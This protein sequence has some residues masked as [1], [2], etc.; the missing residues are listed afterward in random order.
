M[1]DQHNKPRFE[2]PPWEKEAFDRFQQ[3]RARQRA[4][5]ELDEAIRLVRLRKDEPACPDAVGLPPSEGAQSQPNKGT[6]AI[7]GAQID[8]MLVELRSEE[9]QTVRTNMPLINGVSVALGLAGV[10]IVIQSAVL[11]VNART[12]EAV[13]M[14]VAA[15]M[16]FVVLATGLG[17]MTAAVLLFRKYHR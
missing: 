6:P 9:Q 5:E 16:S 17:F 7:L 10:L 14:M 1:S 2:P 12:S 4:S 3:E 11:F 8:S 15:T 13:A